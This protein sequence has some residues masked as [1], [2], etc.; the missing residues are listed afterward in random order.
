MIYPCY[1]IEFPI[2]NPYHLQLRFGGAADVRHHPGQAWRGADG[3]KGDKMGPNG[4]KM[5]EK[6]WENDHKTLWESNMAI[7][8]PIKQVPYMFHC[9]G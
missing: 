7:A 5:V 1:R 8:N 2:R 4:G 9:H 3:E 6:W